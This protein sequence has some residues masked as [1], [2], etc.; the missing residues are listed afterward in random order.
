MPR[1]MHRTI[2]TDERAILSTRISGGGGALLAVIGVDLDDQ[3][4]GIARF[5]YGSTDRKEGCLIQGLLSWNILN[6]AEQK[7]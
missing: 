3:D 4:G 7:G 2:V 6:P 1:K 5:L